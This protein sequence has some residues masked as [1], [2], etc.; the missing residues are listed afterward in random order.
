MSKNRDIKHLGVYKLKKFIS[1][2]NQISKDLCF[3]IILNPKSFTKK[4]SPLM[5]K[6][7]KVNHF[8]QLEFSTKRV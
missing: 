3:V 4:V 7:P 5:Q 1:N 8:K 6:T 2:I